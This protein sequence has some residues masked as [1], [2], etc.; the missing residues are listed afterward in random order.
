MLWCHHMGIPRCRGSNHCLYHASFYICFIKFPMVLPL[1]V[2]IV[3]LPTMQLD[4][5]HRTRRHFYRDCKQLFFSR[6]TIFVWKSCGFSLWIL[7]DSAF[8]WQYVQN[9]TEVGMTYIYCQFIVYVLNWTA[10]FIFY[11]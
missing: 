5:L 1:V 4:T 6:I 7:K 2:E 11:Q 3:L 8:T 9:S 10:I